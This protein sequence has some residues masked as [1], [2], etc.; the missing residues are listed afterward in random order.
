MIIKIL[1]LKL[2]TRHSKS[3]S[4]STC[5]NVIY[6]NLAEKLKSNQIEGNVEKLKKSLADIAIKNIP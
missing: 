1:Q 5:L 3:L 6:P 4:I 2:T